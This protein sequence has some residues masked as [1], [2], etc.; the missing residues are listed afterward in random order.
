MTLLP[1]VID[2]KINSDFLLILP[3]SLKVAWCG[4]ALIPL[5]R[6]VIALIYMGCR[7]VKGQRAA[8]VGRPQGDGHCQSV[9]VTGRGQ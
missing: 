8:T 1:R 7:G 5:P 6:A 2:R 9:F 4:K 3:F